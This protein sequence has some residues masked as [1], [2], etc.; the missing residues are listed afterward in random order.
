MST[1]KTLRDRLI[2]LCRLHGYQ[3]N[4]EA[5]MY[6]VTAPTGFLVG[7]TDFHQT[8]VDID[9]LPDGCETPEAALQGLIDD[10]SFP[11]TKCDD[12]ACET[13]GR[14]AEPE[15]EFLDDQPDGRTVNSDLAW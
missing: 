7:R 11:P 14:I 12:P 6:E 8:F 4:F 1:I 5:G 13:C 2:S 10:V 15:V 3:L 9:E